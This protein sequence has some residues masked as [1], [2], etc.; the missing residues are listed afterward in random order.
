MNTDNVA[1][2]TAKRDDHAGA[3]ELAAEALVGAAAGA[4]TGVLA[5]PPGIVIGALLGGAIGA[6]AGAVLHR[7][8][9]EH[10]AANEQLEHD[11]GVIGGNI[12]EAAPGAPPAVRGTFHAATMGAGGGSSQAPSEGPMQTLADE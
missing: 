4:A 11:I 2:D 5:G 10:E 12:G 6:A 7:D 1:V 3:G 9:A 8:H